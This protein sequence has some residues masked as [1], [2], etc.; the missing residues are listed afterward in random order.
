MNDSQDKLNF[1]INKTRE[2]FEKDK[3]ISPIAFLSNK[4]DM[5]LIPGLEFSDE[6]SKDL[7]ANIIQKTCQEKKIIEL[8]LITESWFKEFKKEE[9]FELNGKAVS[10]YEDKK[11]VIMI[12]HET[13]LSNDLYFIPILRNGDDVKLGELEKMKGASGRGRF[14]GFLYSE[15]I[16]NVKH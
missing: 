12:T 13:K 7:F 1:I 11:E 5:I 3:F 2:V 15:D 4:T 14:T 9:D 16:E 6:S 8:F 10:E